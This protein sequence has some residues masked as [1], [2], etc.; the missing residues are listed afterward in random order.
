MCP[1]G[2]RLTVTIRGD[3]VKVEGNLCPRGREYAVQE[4]TEPRRD[5]FTVVEVEGGEIP[6]VPVRTTAPVPKEKM[7]Q[8]LRELAK[9]RLKAP[10]KAGDV[11]ARNVL[12]LGID[13]IATWNVEK[14]SKPPVKIRNLKNRKISTHPKS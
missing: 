13:V 14:A 6:V 9:I 10:V 4:V 3:E 12:G 7:K 2:C 11:V 5:L 1:I 8:I